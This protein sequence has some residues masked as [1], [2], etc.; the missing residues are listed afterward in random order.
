MKNFYIE[1]KFDAEDPDSNVECSVHSGDLTF[2]E[3]KEAMIRLRDH[4]DARIGAESECPFSPKY[5]KK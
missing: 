2:A 5:E 1:A 3:T 4:L